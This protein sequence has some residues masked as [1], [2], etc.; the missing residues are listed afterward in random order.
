MAQILSRDRYTVYIVTMQ[1]QEN[2]N[3]T[4]KTFMKS[5]PFLWSWLASLLLP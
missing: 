4:L 3:Y 1:L 2:N 5:L